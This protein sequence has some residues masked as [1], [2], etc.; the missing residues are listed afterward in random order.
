MELWRIAVRALIAY[1][2]LLAMTRLSG[3]RVVRQATP[4]DF[5]IALIVGDLIDDALWA[6]VSVAKFAGATGS[7][8]VC[9][10]LVKMAAFHSR[11]AF[12]IVNGRA[13]AMLRDGREDGH[14]LRAEQMNE[15]DLAHL[16]RRKGYER[17]DDIHLAL[18]E[19]DHDSSIILAPGAEPATRQD[20]G[21][22]REIVQ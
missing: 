3:K 1:A 4:F 15:L 10:A 13:R 2:Y 16:V 6:E 21:K 9:D 19:R 5:V 22:L 14:Q 20:A 12:R 8:F 17:W 18:V 11:F 7:I